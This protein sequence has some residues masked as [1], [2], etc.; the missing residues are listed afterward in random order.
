MIPANRIRNHPRLP[1]FA[2]LSFSFT[3]FN[4]YH[5]PWAARKG[6]EYTT[7][8]TLLFKTIQKT[9]SNMESHSHDTP[10]YEDDNDDDSEAT[11]S[12]YQQFFGYSSP[13]SSSSVSFHKKKKRDHSNL[14]TIDDDDDDDSTSWERQGAATGIPLQSPT[15]S[16]F[17]SQKN[18]YDTSFFFFSFPS[19]SSSSFIN[20]TNNT[21]TVTPP[22]SRTLFQSLCQGAKLSKPS[23][24]QALAWPI[25][26]QGYSAIVADQTGS[27]KT[28]AYLIPILQRMMLH[29][30]YTPT[31]NKVYG[32]P[33]ILIL[34]PTAELA[35]Q[36]HSVCTTLAN[37]LKN[38]SSSS[39]SSN[40][41]TTMGEKNRFFVSKVITAS[42]K[43]D[44]DIRDQIRMIQT[45]SIQVLISTPGRLSTI[46]RTKHSGLN[47]SHVQTIVLDEVDVL[48]MDETFG[49]QL[50][51][52]GQ[53]TT[54]STTLANTLAAK[55]VQFVFVTAT[56]PDSV[57]QSVKREFPLVK[58]IQGPGLH[59]IASTVKEHLVDVSIPP[60]SSSSSS[61]P[62]V[63]FELKAQQLLKALRNTRCK[64]TLIFCN[65][66]EACRKVENLIS[67]SDRRKR[68][69]YVGA[70]HNAMTAESRLK[71]LHLFAHGFNRPS[72]DDDDKEDE[73]YPMKKKYGK[74]E[75]RYDPSRRMKNASN[76]KD[77]DKT[78]T[79]LSLKRDT[80]SIFGDD[81]DDDNVQHIL[82][83]TD[84]AA[85]GV[86]FDAS[87]VDHV[88]LFDFPK[89]P[90]EY[91][92]RVGRTARAGRQGTCTVFAY[93]WQLPIARK[94]MGRK[95][96]SFTVARQEQDNVGD[97]DQD[98]EYNNK[99][100]TDRKRRNEK[101]KVIR[102]NIEGGN[103]WK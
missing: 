37:H 58:L 80:Q 93:G 48:M 66:V 86:D 8:T 7:W 74:D 41:T 25:L 10:P 24:I 42:G 92:R 103:I 5:R 57:I 3:D 75:K 29:E 33:Q 101:D 83:C 36:I 27:G 14:D 12:R 4:S 69:W 89:D 61:I 79:N 31:R 87:P 99:Q 40:H 91:V 55:A 26:I 6:E 34:A 2:V 81:D 59:R 65:T 50:K 98:E 77:M 100:R 28:L 56:L 67:R 90:A 22:P 45:H 63:G 47:L 64:R 9:N 54:A 38:S 17:Y 21:V 53:A 76:E 51:T 97:N 82:I 18:L 70:Y 85:R 32:S 35:D 39:S 60:S 43:Y 15:T 11:N 84:R 1:S 72:D 30:N 94:I 102:G 78:R 49:P 13:S 95:L 44:T 88:I 73:E 46:L 52:V 71:N 23:R 96:E 68:L 62:N 19:S 20:H 16:H